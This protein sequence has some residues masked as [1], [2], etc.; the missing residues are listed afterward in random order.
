MNRRSCLTNLLEYF[1]KITELIDHG[2][3]VDILYLDFAKVFDKV[4]HRK[5][6]VLLEK[7]RISGHIKGWIKEWLSDRQQRVVLN[8]EY[9]NWLPVTSGVP[10]G[11]VLGPTLFVIF[12]NTLDIYLQD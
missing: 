4:S 2:N 10:Q 3:S 7:H 12:I 8:G 11:S 6:E 1:E 9:S 5:L